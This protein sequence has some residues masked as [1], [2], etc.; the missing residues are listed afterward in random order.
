MFHVTEVVVADF[1]F[2]QPP[3][4]PPRPICLVARELLSGRTHRLSGG[5]LLSRRHPPYPT[6]K[7]ALF[8]T[9]FTPTEIACYIALGWQLPF[10]VL[11]L[12]VEFRNITNGLYLPCGRGLL[13]AS[14]YHGLIELL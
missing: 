10:N 13:G 14:L 5:D 6:G 4:D 9:F 12:Y 2:A 7:D 11:D 3:G 1:E 8:V